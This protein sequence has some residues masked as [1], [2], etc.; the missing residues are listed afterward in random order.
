MK[1]RLHAI[2]IGVTIFIL[3]SSVAGVAASEVYT[4]RKGD[5][6]W[7]IAKKFGVSV[8]AIKQANKISANKPL[9]IDTKLS[10]PTDKWQVASAKWQEDQKA[11]DKT[12][13][14]ALDQKEITRFGPRIAKQ[15][16]EQSKSKDN[17]SPQVVR[18]ALA[19]RG[20]RYVRGGTGAR[21]FDCSGFTRFVY[22]KYGVELPHSSKSQASCG[23]HV[24]KSDLR[25]GDLVFFKTRGGG[26][27]HVGIYI[28]DRKFIHASTPKTGVIVSSLDQPYYASRYKGARRV[29]KEK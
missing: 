14:E 25:E 6:L 21:G 17:E 16:D 20:S 28:G 15:L 11:K 9:K 18:T 29:A 8:D 4:V 22:A 3:L 23:K 24:E 26:I 1:L 2:G 13:K 12:R 19:Y 7:G 5:T 10:I 27:S